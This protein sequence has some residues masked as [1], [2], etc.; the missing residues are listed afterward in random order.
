MDTK[1]KSYHYGKV[2]RGLGVTKREGDFMRGI[3]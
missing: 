3:K 2:H 1:I